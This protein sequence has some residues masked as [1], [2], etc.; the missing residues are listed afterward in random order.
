MCRTCE[1]GWA[2]TWLGE[3]IFSF[4]HELQAAVTGNVTNIINFARNAA[5]NAPVEEAIAAVNKALGYV[6]ECFQ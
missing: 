4:Q 2:D 3:L 1:Q 6:T 5:L